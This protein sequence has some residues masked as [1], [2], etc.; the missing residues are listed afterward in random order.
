MWFQFKMIRF[1]IDFRGPKE[2]NEL[3]AESENPYTSIAVF[4]NKVKE[5]T[6]NF[7]YDFLFF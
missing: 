4:K 6:I 7:F 1:G 3:L 5:K 2:R